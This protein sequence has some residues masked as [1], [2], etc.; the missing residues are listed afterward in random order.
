MSCS[1]AVKSQYGLPRKTRIYRKVLTGPQ[2]LPAFFRAFT[3]DQSFFIVQSYILLSTGFCLRP[4]LTKRSSPFSSSNSRISSAFSEF[5]RP[6]RFPPGMLLG[7]RPLRSPGFPVLFPSCF[8]LP[9]P[10]ALWAS[11]FVFCPGVSLRTPIHTQHPNQVTVY[12]I[13]ISQFS[14]IFLSLLVSQFKF[15][16]WRWS[17]ITLQ[18]R[19]RTA[20]CQSP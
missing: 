1:D 16:F 19:L 15:M 2:L 11:S 9:F 3:G 17:N 12:F 8:P 10:P 7:Y 5:L 14:K 4:R 20:V 13:I 6:L 18:I